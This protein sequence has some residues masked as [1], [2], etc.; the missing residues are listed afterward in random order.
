MVVFIHDHVDRLFLMTNPPMLSRTNA[1]QHSVI[2]VLKITRIAFFLCFLLEKQ[3]N[4]QTN[5]KCLPT[6]F[7]VARHFVIELFPPIAI[8]LISACKYLHKPQKCKMNV[9]GISIH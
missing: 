8:N 9:S 4:K 7:S 2:K 6:Q 3:T 1:T 5:N